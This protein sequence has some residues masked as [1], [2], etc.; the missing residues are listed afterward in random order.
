MTALID[1]AGR[2]ARKLRVSLTD[3]CDLRCFYCMPAE[4]SFL[5]HERLLPPAELERICGLLAAEGVEEIRLT[6][7]EPTL[8]P[9]FDEIVERLGRLPFRRHALTSNGR[10]LA[11][12]FDRLWSSGFR[13]LNLSLD[14]LD[15]AV[16]ARITRSDAFDAV[17]AA[18]LE[19]RER[20]FRVKLNAVLFRGINDGEAPAFARF[21]AEHGIPVR[22]LELMRIGPDHE[23]NRELLV[24]A[25][26]TVD[27]LRRE[28]FDLQPLA[29]PV[30]AT[31]FEY[32]TPEGGRVG[33]IASETQ[34]FCGGCSRLRLTATGELRACLLKPEGVPLKGV[35][36]EALPDLLR[37]VLATKPTERLH[38]TDE[39][40][41]RIGG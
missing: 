39:A 9:D 18:V 16:F 23:R 17:L 5:P 10:R 22:F 14:S 20:G 8:R 31:A 1:P 36:A 19:A 24:P 21:S 34:P 3:A 40:M 4:M 12:R 13:D 29:T 30:D 11:G 35:A 2:R 25:Q 27:L 37:R 6:G 15:P 7:G 28:A 38:H 32:A 26:E 41:I 33:F